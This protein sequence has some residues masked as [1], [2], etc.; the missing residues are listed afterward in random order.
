MANNSKF[1]KKDIKQTLKFL[2]PIKEQVRGSRVL[3]ICGGI[4]RCGSILSNLFDEVDVCDLSPSFGNLPSE[5]QGRLIKS[6]LKD[7]GQH[8]RGRHYD[9]IFGNWALCY[10]GFKE[11]E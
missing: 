10:I 5:K 7:I 2:K 3:D 11:M 6:N 8:I 9:C 4:S 1:S